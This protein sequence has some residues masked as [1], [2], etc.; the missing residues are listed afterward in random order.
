MWAWRRA[1]KPAQRYL[2]RPRPQFFERF[3]SNAILTQLSQIGKQS[4]RIQYTM[5]NDA[6][7]LPPIG[8]A[9]AA[10]SGSVTAIVPAR[11]EEA[12]IAACIASLASQPEI[13]EIL[14]VNDQS[15]D[16]TA[17]VVTNLMGKISNLRLLP[18]R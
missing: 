3:S 16:G 5:T 14:V 6:H 17:S 15:T 1:P 2:S 18:G 10:A 12:V 7:R 8:A 4:F 9:P 11:D 13:G